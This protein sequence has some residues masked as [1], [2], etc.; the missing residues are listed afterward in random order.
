MCI[1][2]HMYIL[3]FMLS[4]LHVPLWFP[5]IASS[6]RCS[7]VLF[8]PLPSWTQPRKVF[9]ARSHCQ[10]LQQ[11]MGIS[12]SSEPVGIFRSPLGCWRTLRDFQNPHVLEPT[13]FTA[14]STILWHGPHPLSYCH[15]KFQME[16]SHKFSLR[17]VPQLQE[18][19]TI[20]PLP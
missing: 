12:V 4:V 13:T 3:P 1:Y 15:R 14:L 11:L 17:L 5:G 9:D 8:G 2:M 18:K 7:H 19:P 20:L 6:L 16:T 10:P